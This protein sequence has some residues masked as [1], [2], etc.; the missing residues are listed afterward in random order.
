M[1]SVE[2]AMKAPVIPG[3][4]C[5]APVSRRTPVPAR[6]YPMVITPSP[7]PTHPDVSRCG[8]NG[9]DLNDGCRH[10][11]LHDN[12]DRSCYNQHWKRDSE[13]NADMDPCTY[14]GDSHCSQGQNCES[15]FHNVY[16]FDAL[17][18]LSMLTNGLPLC[19]K[20]EDGIRRCRLDAS[21]RM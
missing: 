15:I 20:T 3:V 4:I 21:S 11:R 18:E 6:P 9:C 14:C 17:G 2:A 12:R 8:A 10:R 7:T 16:P 19:N 5:V 1:P 13:V